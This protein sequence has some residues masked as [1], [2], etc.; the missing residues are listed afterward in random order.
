MI[1]WCT[2]N[3][4]FHCKGAENAFFV[5]FS[6]LPIE[7]MCFDSSSYWS[8]WSPRSKTLKITP[9]YAFRF[10]KSHKYP[11]V[12]GFTHLGKL[13]PKKFFW[14]APVSVYYVIFTRWGERAVQCSNGGGGRQP[15]QHSRRR[16]G[17]LKDPGL[18]GIN[19]LNNLQWP[20]HS[21]VF[22]QFGSFLSYVNT[23]GCPLYGPQVPPQTLNSFSPGFV[24]YFTSYYVQ[25]R[26]SIKKVKYRLG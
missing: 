6:W 1:L 2:K 20:W 17:Q 10:P 9:N 5:L 23:S 25:K 16:L 7:I 26:T 11:G 3:I 8:Y 19:I 24:P 18:S 12:G 4:S 22:D 15:G 13:S 14:T 21:K